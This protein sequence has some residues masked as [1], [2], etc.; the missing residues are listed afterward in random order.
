MRRTNKKA[1]ASRLFNKL[2]KLSALQV[3]RQE[4]LQQQE[5]RLV[6]LQQQ[7]QLQRREQ[8]LVRQQEQQLFR[9]KQTKT[10]PTVRRSGRR[11]SFVFPSGYKFA[12]VLDLL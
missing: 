3:Q 2:V 6:R 5:R 4:Q 8:R 12:G 11:I 1:D 10:E 9:H 7:E